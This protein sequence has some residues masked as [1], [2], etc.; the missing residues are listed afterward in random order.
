[1]CH[2]IV[3]AVENMEMAERCVAKFANGGL[4]QWGYITGD[5]R[6]VSVD[7]CVMCLRFE[8]VFFNKLLIVVVVVYVVRDA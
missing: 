6:F 1:M 7:L 2:N 3:I 4:R 5:D 8:R